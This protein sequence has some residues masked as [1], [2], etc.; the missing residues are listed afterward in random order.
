MTSTV[1]LALARLL[2]SAAFSNTCPSP[3]LRTDIVN[4]PCIAAGK[5]M[6]SVR[7]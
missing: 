6:L 3:S 1:P 5:R 2:A 4:R 7:V